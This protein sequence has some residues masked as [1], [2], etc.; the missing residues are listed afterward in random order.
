MVVATAL[1]FVT[2]G[3]P[4]ALVGQNASVDRETVSARATDVMNALQG[5]GERALSDYW[6][7]NVMERLPPATVQEAW[8]SVVSMLG[9]PIDVSDPVVEPH[10]DGGWTARIT[11]QFSLT[12]L[13]VSLVFD[14]AGLVRGVSMGG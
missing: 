1:L 4:A 2:A 13:P 8:T 7:P 11:V 14:D 10:E 9:A 12:P 6:A 5:I 3:A